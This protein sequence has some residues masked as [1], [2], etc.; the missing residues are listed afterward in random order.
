MWSDN[1]NHRT[2]LRCVFVVVF[3]NF[4]LLSHSASLPPWLTLLC[5]LS[6]IYSRTMLLFWQDICFDGFPLSNYFHFQN[7]TELKVK[8]SVENAGL[9]RQNSLTLLLWIRRLKLWK[10]ISEDQ[11]KTKA[12]KRFPS[13]SLI[14][15]K[16][17]S[18][19]QLRN[20]RK[21]HS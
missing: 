20:G 3:E 11:S 19:H 15:G 13:W 7:D 21:I 1:K 12:E 9:E 4:P 14:L 17:L 18:E 2:S 5:R 16:K 10:K 6:L 8:D